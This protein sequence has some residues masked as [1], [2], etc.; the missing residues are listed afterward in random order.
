MDAVENGW[1]PGRGPGVEQEGW[2]VRRRK[3]W[4]GAVELEPAGTW[5][6]DKTRLE[7][8]SRY[9]QVRA[10]LRADVVRVCVCVFLC[11]TLGG[12]LLTGLGLSM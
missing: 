8:T 7:S 10:Y 12:L 11:L 2:V 5:S 4:R 6:G 9:V 3:S 1:E